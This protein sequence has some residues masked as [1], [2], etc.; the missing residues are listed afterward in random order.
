MALVQLARNT[1]RTTGKVNLP[2]F[3]APTL[4]TPPSISILMGL[5]ATAGRGEL[6]TRRLSKGV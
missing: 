6:A 5:I 3:S 2:S 4:T 1:L